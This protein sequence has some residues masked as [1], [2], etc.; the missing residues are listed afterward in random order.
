MILFFNRED[1]KLVIFVHT[2]ILFADIKN[3]DM[4]TGV[5][6]KIW[7]SKMNVE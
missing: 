3:V 1:I 7:E 6:K 5:S 2:I 4:T